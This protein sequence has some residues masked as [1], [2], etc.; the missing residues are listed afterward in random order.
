VGSGVKA[1]YRH[2]QQSQNMGWSVV[3]RSPSKKEASDI[4]ILER[5]AE[6]FKCSNSFDALLN[7]HEQG[8]KEAR[9]I[10]QLVQGDT[11]LNDR[12]GIATDKNHIVEASQ[13]HDDPTTQMHISNTELAKIVENAQAAMMM[14]TTPKNG[15][16]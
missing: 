2:G 16:P 15:Q 8:E 12:L 1:G 4:K 6:T 9:N 13:V 14:N 10:L 5:A 3:H 7:V 11:G